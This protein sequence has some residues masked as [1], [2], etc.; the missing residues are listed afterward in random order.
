MT[1]V[2]GQIGVTVQP[3]A[4]LDFKQD[5]KLLLRL[6]RLISETWEAM[7]A[8]E[9]KRLEKETAFLNPVKV[10]CVPH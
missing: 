9:E 7:N 8:K 1:F 5:K 10:L 3:A 4:D 6:S 2:L